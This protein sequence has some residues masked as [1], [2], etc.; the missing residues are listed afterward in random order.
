MVSSLPAVR[1]AEI[2]APAATAHLLVAITAIHRPAGARLE[3][4]LGVDAA[5]GALHFVHLFRAAAAIA[6]GSAART[7][8]AAITAAAAIAI[9]VRTA[10]L[11][12]L[13]GCTAVGAAARIAE[14]T[15][16]VEFLF[17]CGKGELLAAIAARQCPVS[18][19]THGILPQ[20][21]CQPGTRG[22][23][24]ASYRESKF[25]RSKVRVCYQIPVL[26]YW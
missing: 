15:G 1:L 25:L 10:A 14:T 13:A 17:P 16:L 6:A 19:R 21:L 3:R 11:A 5:V 7:A 22:V 2:L 8:P 23:T 18:K 26:S 9:A 4:H 24:E 20:R 12:A